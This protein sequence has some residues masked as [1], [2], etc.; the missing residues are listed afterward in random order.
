MNRYFRNDTDLP[1][2]RVVMFVGESEVGQCYFST[3][4]LGCEWE[5]SECEDHGIFT[6]ITRIEALRIVPSIP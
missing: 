4:R 2:K 6:E 5:L 1:P 3:G